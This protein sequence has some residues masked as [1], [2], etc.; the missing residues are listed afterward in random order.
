MGVFGTWARLEPAAATAALEPTVV[1]WEETVSDKGSKGPKFSPGGGGDEDIEAPLLL[2]EDRGGG[3]GGA[4]S[5]KGEFGWMCR[6]QGGEVVWQHSGDGQG[7]GGGGGG[8]AVKECAG[9]Q[10]SYMSAAPDAS[11]EAAGE[12]RGVG[13]GGGA[14]YCTCARVDEI[15]VFTKMF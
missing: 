6:G 3:E 9:S 1:A 13:G 10:Y 12:M 7:V 8:G 2:N 5:R 14:G 11:D 15:G 4:E